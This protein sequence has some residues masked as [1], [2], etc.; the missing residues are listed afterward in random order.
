MNQKVKLGN[1]LHY[2]DEYIKKSEDI[3]C[4]CCQKFNHISRL[5]R[6]IEPTCTKCGLNMHETNESQKCLANSSGDCKC[7][8]CGG[9]H[10]A[11][12]QVVSCV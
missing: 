8:H 10:S 7:C 12:V 5:C 1:Q 2:V 6:S 9:N 4:N 11:G 3:K